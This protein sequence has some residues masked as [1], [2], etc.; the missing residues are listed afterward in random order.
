LLS[1]LIEDTAAEGTA[2]YTYTNASLVVDHE[3]L[4][5]VLL[6]G[7]TGV[8]VANYLLGGGTQARFTVG[9]GITWLMNRRMQLSANYDF[10]TQNG[11]SQTTSIPPPNLTAINTGGYSRSLF[12]VAV[13]FGL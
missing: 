11:V 3:Y 1:R 6:Q 10:T 7:R 5:N 8:Q 9:A 2:G 4:R 13:H 12:L